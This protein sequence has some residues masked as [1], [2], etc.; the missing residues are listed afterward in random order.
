MHAYN[1]RWVSDRKE[2]TTA[3]TTWMNVELNRLS[4]K[5]QPQ[6]ATYI[7]YG[8][9][10]GGPGLG[11]CASKAGGMSSIPQQGTRIS[12]AGLVEQKKKKK[13]IYSMNP[14]IGW[15]VKWQEEKTGQ[16]LSGTGSR[17]RGWLHRGAHGNYGGDGAWRCDCILPKIRNL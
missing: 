12:H 3:T 8:D 6:K 13:A 5:S 15:M 9:F 14:F 17:A 16:C 1:G 4:E 7:W 2:W 11:L 10:P